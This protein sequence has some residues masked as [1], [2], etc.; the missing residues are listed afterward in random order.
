[1]TTEKSKTEAYEVGYGKP[2]QHSRFKKGQSGNPAGG[3]KGPRSFDDFVDRVI[4]EKMRVTKDGRKRK[5]P[6]MEA[7][8]NTVVNKALAGDMK[9]I[10]Y[11]MNRR[12]GAQDN[13]AP[14]VD[15]ATASALAK[16]VLD[17]YLANLQIGS[18]SADTPFDDGLAGQAPVAVPAP[19]NENV[20]LAL[21]GDIAVVGKAK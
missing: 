5:M 8:A 15:G 17:D 16:A 13:A 4:S 9:A 20:E 14:L 12:S 19:S 21:P 10:I 18:Y 2:P 6:K 11:V 3:K 1:M 7:I